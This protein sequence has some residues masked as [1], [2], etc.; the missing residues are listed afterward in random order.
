MHR[1]LAFVLCLC[2]STVACASDPGN[3]YK[4]TYDGG[5]LST[6]KAGDSAK[7]FIEESRFASPK[8]RT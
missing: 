5:S 7:L 3:S 6:A 1:F 4:I 8:A 2:V